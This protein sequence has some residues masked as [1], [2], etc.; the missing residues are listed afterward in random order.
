M[1]WASKGANFGTNKP[2]RH[3]THE[4]FISINCDGT[5]YV[6]S[7]K[8]RFMPGRAFFLPEGSNHYIAAEEGKS[9]EFAFVCFEA[10]HF[11]KTGNTQA[12]KAVDF[13]AGN[14]QYFS[15]I[16][17]EYLRKNIRLIEN[18][19]EETETSLPLSS[20]K[21]DCLLGELII[22]YY[23][24]VKKSFDEIEN[25]TGT[26]AIQNLVGKI[27]LH[28]EI[29][30]TLPIS[31][32]NAGMSISKFCN[33]LR[34]FTGTT[35]MAY[36]NDARLKKAVELI[37]TNDMQISRISLEC[38]FTNLGYFHKIFKKQYGISPLVMKKIFRER[39][40]FPKIIKEIVI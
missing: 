13:L 5:Q 26:E 9:A 39:G 15:G 12:Q 35:L 7:E 33:N 6:E 11:L 32:K 29:D 16:E 4:L 37:K 14:R 27:L 31:A 19:M 21:A 25:M 10:K 30:Y 17:P 22:N 23:R 1:L 40:H 2:H 24:S 3:M 36:V 28:P 18:I 8:C 34:K 38:G 20:W